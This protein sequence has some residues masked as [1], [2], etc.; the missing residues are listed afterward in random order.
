M[1]DRAAIME[2]LMSAFVVAGWWAFTRAQSSPRWG[3]L[4]GVFAVLAYFTKAAAVFFIAAL[5]L[6][7]LAS[8]YDGWRRPGT[9]RVP[10]AAAGWTI[11]GIAAALL[12]A[13]AVFVAPAWSEYR[14]YNWQMSVTRKPSYDLDSIV[15]RIT[16]FP[17]LHDVLTRMWLVA[18][19]GA[20]AWVTRVVAWNRIGPPERLLTLWV[21]VGVAELLAHDV[22]NERRFV[23]LIPALVA[24]AALTLARDRTL[25]PD[26]L[27][28]VSRR[29]AIL[30]L[31][32]VGY[33]LYIVCGS[34]VRLAF[35]YEVR[36]AVRLSAVVAILLLGAGWWGWSRLAPWLAQRCSPA[37][38]G[39]LAAILACGGVA[40]FAQW[41]IGRTLQER[42]GVSRTGP[43]APA[44][45]AG[46]RE[47]RQR[48]GTRKPHPAGLRRPRVR[49][50]R[51]P[52]HA[53]RCTMAGDLRRAARR[54]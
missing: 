42:R 38:A 3:A 26:W 8:L 22:G 20:V 53:E 9:S 47:A 39:L 48:A 16:W 18:A 35:L 34:I 6:A 43:A 24:L 12:V 17:I 13:V 2:S 27:P 14:F 30:L 40:Q 51:R 52:A 44:R 23:F 45:H 31:P 33:V 41:A 15:T 36:P 10:A 25:L 21:G 1:Y 4:A 29:L 32:L 28:A 37:T 5:G 50:L 11:A 46:P 54:L 19:V 49:Q 7:A